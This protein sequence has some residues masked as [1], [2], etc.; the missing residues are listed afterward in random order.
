MLLYYFKIYLINTGI[1]WIR[2]RMDPDPHG[3]RTKKIQSWIQIRNKPIRIHN[4]AY[5]V[6]KS[7]GTCSQCCGADAAWINLQNWA[8]ITF[9]DLN[10]IFYLGLVF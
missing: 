6:S 8:T 2:I 10:T 7:Y 9:N 1:G 5:T 3:S 4:T